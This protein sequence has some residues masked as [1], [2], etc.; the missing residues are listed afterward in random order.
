MN[1]PHRWRKNRLIY[2][3]SL[4][5]LSHVLERISELIR[6]VKKIFLTVMANPNEYVHQQK[7]HTNS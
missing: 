1:H 7:W 4:N 3:L 5:K 6:G 2:Y